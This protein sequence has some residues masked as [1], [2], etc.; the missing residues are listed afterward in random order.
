MSHDALTPIGVIAH[1]NLLEAIDPS[2]LG[3]LF[4][5][6]DTKHGRTVALRLL[7]ADFTPDRTQF[8][9]AI[10]GVQVLSHPNAITV[11]DVGGQLMVYA[12]REGPE[13]L[14]KDQTGIKGFDAASRLEST[15][16]P[17]GQCSSGLRTSANL[18]ASRRSLRMRPPACR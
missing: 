17:S 10:R 12:G 16:S 7:P 13:T 4:R 2:G 15:F 5:A 11:F 14:V 6:R 9:N 8:V 1:Y 3:E 18:R